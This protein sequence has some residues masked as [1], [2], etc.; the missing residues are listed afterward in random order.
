MVPPSTFAL[1]LTALVTPAMAQDIK[2]HRL[3]PVPIPQV[4]IEDDFWSPKLRVWREVTIP[5]CFAKFEKDGALT[6]LRQDPRW[7]RRRARRPAVV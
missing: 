4:E 2:P 3:T 6:Q 5:D 1:L 7:H